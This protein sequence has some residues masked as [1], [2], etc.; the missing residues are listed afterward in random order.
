M[1]NLRF[2]VSHVPYLMLQTRTNSCLLQLLYKFQHDSFSSVLFKIW[3]LF[4]FV[5]HFV[6][7]FVVL[8][9]YSICVSTGSYSLPFVLLYSIVSHIDT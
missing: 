6:V 2:L 5:L 7:V 9:F 4:W 3:V 8:P 1:F